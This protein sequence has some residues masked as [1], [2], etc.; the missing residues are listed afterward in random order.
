MPSSSP[1][2]NYSLFTMMDNSYPLH[3]NSKNNKFLLINSIHYYIY[4]FKQMLYKGI[5]LKILLF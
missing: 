2:E 4:I 5:T 1:D 3:G